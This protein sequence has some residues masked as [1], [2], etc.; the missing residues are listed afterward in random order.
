VVGGVRINGTE[1][2]VGWS[3]LVGSCAGFGLSSV[4]PNGAWEYEPVII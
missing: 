1:G 3:I 4:G 2:V